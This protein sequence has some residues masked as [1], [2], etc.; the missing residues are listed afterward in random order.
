MMF[1]QWILSILA[2]INIPF[3]RGF[4]VKI[5]SYAC[6]AHEHY[7]VV[8]DNIKFSMLVY[9]AHSYFFVWAYLR[10]LQGGKW[11][12]SFASIWNTVVWL[13]LLNFFIKIVNS[14]AQDYLKK[15]QDQE[16][17]DFT[18]KSAP[19]SSEE[20]WNAHL[21]SKI[22]PFFLLRLTIV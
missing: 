22:L 13:M 19:T 8:Y 15:Q 21:L 6:L 17:H 12:F 1:C 9:C 4:I 11:D 3:T 7:P 18:G 20:Q 5:V 16:L 10:Y 14:T 2:N